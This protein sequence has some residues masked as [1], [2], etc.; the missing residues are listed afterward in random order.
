MIKSGVILIPY[1][2][3]S[4]KNRSSTISKYEDRK[5]IVIDESRKLIH[6]KPIIEYSKSP[7]QLTQSRS[8]I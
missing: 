8:Q 3:S 7:K 4:K 6:C 1:F 2:D 5:L